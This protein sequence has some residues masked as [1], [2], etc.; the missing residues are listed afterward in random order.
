MI[1]C[2][3]DQNH[4]ECLFKQLIANDT[5]TGKTKAVEMS[6]K[7]RE[8][9]LGDEKKDMCDILCSLGNT[10]HNE[11]NH[12]R[13]ITRQYH[14]KG[15]IITSSLRHHSNDLYLLDLYLIIKGPL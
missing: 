10:S 5:K 11:A 3:E 2:D 13:I 9:L 14:V 1:R 15:I 4:R 12:A 6:Q 8:K 7:L